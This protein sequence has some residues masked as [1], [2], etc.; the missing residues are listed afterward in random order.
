MPK[1]TPSSNPKALRARPTTPKPVGSPALDPTSG[2]RARLIACGLLEQHGAV[3]G[4]FGTADEVFVVC[5]AWEGVRD[6]TEVVY[7]AKFGQRAGRQRRPSQAEWQDAANTCEAARKA[8]AGQRPTTLAGAIE[9]LRVTS[10]CMPSGD[11]MHSHVFAAVRDFL[12]LM[13]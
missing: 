1:A 4:T 2:D 12:T 8:L 13:Q 9:K 5:A 10:A 6:R 7:A 3:V 11:G